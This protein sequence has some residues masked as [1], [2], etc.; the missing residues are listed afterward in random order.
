MILEQTIDLLKTRYK[1]RIEKLT[2]ADVRMGIYL[3]AVRLSDGSC[4]VASTDIES[5]PPCCKK[6]RDYGDFTPT[7]IVGQRL[8]D[9]LESDKPL[10][11]LDT[12]KV[13]SLNAVS[14]KMLSESEYR[15]I[16]DMDPVDLVDLNQ[17]RTITLVGG[18]H[19]YIQ[20]IAATDN[21][22]NVL[23]LDENA[24]REDQKKYYVPAEEYVNI[25]PVSDVVIIT[26]LTLVNNTI[27]G[28]I[29]AI[30][31]H[32]QVIVAGPSSS[33]LPDVLF[34]NKVN[35]IGA[36]K[37]TDPDKAFAVAGEAGSGYH[38]FKYCARK[39]CILNEKRKPGF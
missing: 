15:I 30:A 27:D 33:L 24:L 9:L 31:P 20:R 38:L 14:M 8:I 10:K 22:L 5:H 28:L 4:G 36:T 12:L 21:K 13:S 19:S 32:S 34:E 26:G 39:I 3:T 7:K 29:G 1:E 35:I 17:H 6:D 23:E 2:I 16:E 37:I 11:A 25:L 18:F